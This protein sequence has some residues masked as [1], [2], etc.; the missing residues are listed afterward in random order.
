LGNR[1]TGS[2]TGKGFSGSNCFNDILTSLNL[3]IILSCD[4]PTP[5]LSSCDKDENTFVIFVCK[6]LI[7]EYRAFISIWLGLS[8]IW[9]LCCIVINLLV[10]SFNLLISFL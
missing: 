2:G 5:I 10:L 4:V 7:L 9:I 1:G 6:I 3:F 8:N